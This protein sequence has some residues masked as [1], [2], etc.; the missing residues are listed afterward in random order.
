[1]ACVATLCR[2]LMIS[3]GSLCESGGVL[4]KNNHIKL[5]RCLCRKKLQEWR[6][7]KGISYKRPPL[8]VR[9]QAKRAVTT[10]RP[11]CATGEGG[12]EAHS[13][14]CAVDRSLADCVKLLGEVSVP[15]RV[16]CSG[17]CG[18]AA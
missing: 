13:L 3:D 14:I 7:A 16:R 10:S 5:F 15:P 12:D 2:F 11:V 17:S 18:V 8:P 4:I 9:A 6:E 1:M